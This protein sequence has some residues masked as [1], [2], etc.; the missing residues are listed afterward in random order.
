[1][2]S[3][4]KELLKEELIRLELKN[5]SRVVDIRDY[6]KPKEP[7]IKELDLASQFTPGKTLE[8]LTPK[9]REAVNMLL[10]LTLGKKK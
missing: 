10:R 8:S 3:G 2:T 5:G 4:S 9:E 1:M 6:M 7:K